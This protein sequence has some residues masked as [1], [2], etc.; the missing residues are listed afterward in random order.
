MD[1]GGGYFMAS[2]LAGAVISACISKLTPIQVPH[3]L[4]ISLAILLSLPFI[5]KSNRNLLYLC[6]ASLFL[7]GYANSLRSSHTNNNQTAGTNKTI[8]M[9]RQFLIEKASAAVSDPQDRAVLTALV[10]GDKRGL[11]PSTKM[12]YKNSGAM[13]ILALSGLHIGIIYTMLEWALFFLGKSVFSRQLKIVVCTLLLLFY[14]A[15]TGFSPS[16]QRAT[17]MA[18]T[19]KM[20]QLGNRKRGKWDALLLSATI[21]L[22]FD[23]HSLLEIGFQLSFASVAGIIGIYPQIRKA[24][25][26][27]EG[28]WYGKFLN[29]IW[30]I[31]AISVA[32][33]I[34]TAPLTLYYFKQL[35]FYFLITNIVALPLVP[36]IIYAF[37][38]STFFDR[39][40]LVTEWLQT[41]AGHILQLMNYLINLIGG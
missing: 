38:F 27:W 15:M 18:V 35:P 34:T 36:I 9:A 20:L 25:L 31:M 7:L 33:Q 28:K 8:I 1:R 30:N 12:A 17:I 14:G 39:V 32:C 13:H 19:L 24:A 26:L 41:L 16:V 21:I 11:D 4:P 40:P 37:S 3:I 6:Y 29:P 10:T 22:L 5:T 2:F 23:P